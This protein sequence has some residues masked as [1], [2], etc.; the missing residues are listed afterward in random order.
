MKKIF[1][2]IA[3]LAILIV[4]SSAQATPVQIYDPAV[5]NMISSLKSACSLVGID[6]WGTEYYTYQGARRCELHFGDSRDNTIRFRL[7]NDDSIARVLVTHR[8]NY[9][10]ANDIN[11]AE[12]LIV[13]AT[14][15][16]EIGL[17]ESECQ[18]LI[19]KLSRKISQAGEYATYFHDKSSVWCSK[20]KRYVTLDLEVDHSKVD[21]YLY[22][23]I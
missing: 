11:A 17:T 14:V 4:S 15:L 18:A 7:N 2:L 19:D 5:R 12:I 8:L 6:I 13:V 20:A 10:L 23:S 3:A 21:W 9:F 1:V 22:S 16:N